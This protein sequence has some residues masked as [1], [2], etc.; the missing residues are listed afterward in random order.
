MSGE[1]AFVHSALGRGG[2]ERLRYTVLKELA[3][4]N[5]PCRV[6]LFKG[7]GDL[8]PAVRDLGIPVDVLNVSGKL[9]SLKTTLRLAAWLKRT[10]PSVV[11]GGQ[12]LTNLHT[13]MA[14]KLAGVGPVILEEHGH[15]RWKRWHHRLLD[16]HVCSRADGV[17][18]CSDSVRRVAQSSMLVPDDRFHVLHNCIDLS[19]I[20]GR[21]GT[22]SIV[23]ASLNVADD[24]ILVGTVGTL[25]PEKGHSVLIRAWRQLCDQHPDIR[26]KLVIVGDGP[27]REQLHDEAKDVPGIV[28]A[29]S[30]SDVGEVLAAMDVFVFP[31][32]DEG[33]GIALLEAMATGLPSVVSN[34]GGIPEIVTD[35]ETGI[36]VAAGDS[37]ALSDGLARASIQAGLRVKLGQAAKK[38]ALRGHSPAVYCRELLELH[39]QMSV[40]HRHHNQ[41]VQHR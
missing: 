35:G 25:R 14:S 27:I 33:L 37:N 3:E 18:C 13:T 32:V 41:Q 40:K 24:E 30:R 6:C 21:S 38:V 4:Q 8:V 22:R 12:F 28:W 10:Q 29:G 23:R 31:S 9:Y 34:E 5:V 36:V 15:N 19:E 26:A 11:H 7:D 39:R 16:R 2:A 20:G 1:I 17:V